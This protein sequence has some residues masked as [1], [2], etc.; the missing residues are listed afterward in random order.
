MLIS[1]GGKH[2]SSS[3]AYI[4]YHVK[5]D[6]NEI[7]VYFINNDS[8][9]YYLISDHLFKK[10]LFRKTDI[11]YNYTKH[12]LLKN[13]EYEINNSSSENGHNY[14]LNNQNKYSKNILDFNRRFIN[15]VLD[16]YVNY[17]LFEKS[18]ISSLI[19]Q[20]TTFIGQGIMM[21]F[22][23]KDT[24]IENIVFYKKIREK[25]K[26]RLLLS[27]DGLSYEDE[28]SGMIYP[29]KNIFSMYGITSN[30]K[31]TLEYPMQIEGFKR[32]DSKFT[33]EPLEF[34]IKEDGGDIM[35]TKMPDVRVILEK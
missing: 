12:L 9:N 17:G 33:T 19:S 30:T 16:D 27:Y 1:C 3:D 34:E 21:P 10:T 2:L 23:Q 25:G 28:I 35:V 26:Y 13:R 31:L 22:A 11:E 18:K 8:V 24:I 6:S 15:R 14:S 7:K 32:M 5:I 20:D 4:A 29:V